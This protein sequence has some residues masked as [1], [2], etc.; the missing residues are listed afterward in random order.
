VVLQPVSGAPI[1]LAVQGRSAPT[2]G[3]GSFASF[4]DPLIDDAGRIAFVAKLSGV[5]ASQ[6]TAVF[7]TTP[8]GPIRALQQGVEIAGTDGLRLRSILGTSWQNSV[9]L[10]S[11][12]VTGPGV[13]ATNNKVLLSY[14]AAGGAKILLRTGDMVEADGATSEIRAIGA[15]TPLPGLTG[16]CR[17]QGLGKI[18]A[19][20]TLADKR[21]VVITAKIDGSSAAVDL[22]SGQL[23]GLDV[24]AQWESFG[25][26]AIDPSGTRRAVLGKQAIGPGKVLAT[27]DTAIVGSNGGGAFVLIARE[28]SVIPS[29]SGFR[30]GTLRDPIVNVQGRV[31][32]LS[33]VRGDGVTTKN[34]TCILQAS[35]KGTNYRLVARNGDPAASTTGEIEPDL[36]YRSFASIALPGAVLDGTIFVARL[37]G[38]GV[39]TR[40]NVGLFEGPTDFSTARRLLRTGDRLGDRVIAAINVLQARA[41]SIGATRAFSDASHVA[42]QLTFTD[43]STAIIR[44][45]LP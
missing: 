28:G 24:G 21:S 3:T 36:F 7:I 42:A 23:S 31:A 16:H 33:T 8:S 2:P 19:R 30:Y 40:N 14:T 45:N 17:T 27:D 15:L 1:V 35:V 20:A 39:T 18:I 5:P 41:G 22:H 25:V 26:P 11:A 6:A 43:R 10:V 44:L 13:K 9:L 38:E 12:T 4:S 29:L 32:W 34:D 37:S